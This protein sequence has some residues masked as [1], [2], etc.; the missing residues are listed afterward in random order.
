VTVSFLRV[1]SMASMSAS[2]CL[3]AAA[4]ASADSARRV[5]V[6]AALV[7]AADEAMVDPELFEQFGVAV[8]DLPELGGRRGQIL[9]FGRGQVGRQRQQTERLF[10]GSGRLGQ[11]L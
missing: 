1:A 11:D 5:A 7:A 2:R 3:A 4:A 10:R 6:S 9:M 8:V